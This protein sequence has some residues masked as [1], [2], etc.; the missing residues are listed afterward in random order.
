M[1]VAIIDGVEKEIV[2]YDLSPKGICGLLKLNEV[3]YIETCTWGHF[4]RGFNWDK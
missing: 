3:K 1:A 4:G 2:E